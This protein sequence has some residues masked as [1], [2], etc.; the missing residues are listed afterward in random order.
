MRNFK[1]NQANYRYQGEPNQL[2]FDSQQKVLNSQKMNIID[3][4][5]K[6]M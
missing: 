2:L 4:Q 6:K 5:K 1:V 3:V